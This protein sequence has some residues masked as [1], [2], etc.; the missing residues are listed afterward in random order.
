MVEF[1]GTAQNHTTH[2]EQS[3]PKVATPICDVPRLY[4][5][6]LPGMPLATLETQPRPSSPRHIMHE[7]F[8]EI[9]AI[10]RNIILASNVSLMLQQPALRW[11]VAAA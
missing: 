6:C 8:M 7:S 4:M 2:G 3:L 5:P 1:E 10:V 11:H 9:L